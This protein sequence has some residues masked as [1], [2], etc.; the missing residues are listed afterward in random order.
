M[1]FK[2]ASAIRQ[3][4]RSDDSVIFLVGDKDPFDMICAD[5]VRLM[6]KRCCTKNVA[7]YLVADAPNSEHDRAVQSLFY[8]KI[9]SPCTL[10][11]AENGGTSALRCRIEQADVMITCIEGDTERTAWLSEYEGELRAKR[12]L[13]LEDIRLQPRDEALRP[14][15]SESASAGCKRHCTIACIRKYWLDQSPA[16]ELLLDQTLEFLIRRRGV[17]TFWVEQLGVNSPA[18]QAVRRIKAAYRDIELALIL[19]DEV[20][21]RKYE[22]VYQGIYDQIFCSGVKSKVL[23]SKILGTYNL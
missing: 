6:R 17:T 5:E 8:D 1:R 19:H 12:V 7:L 22:S 13:H 4:I 10:P 9:V 14:E 3:V 15:N 21:L 18:V 20:S 16:H 23:R 2:V 11:G